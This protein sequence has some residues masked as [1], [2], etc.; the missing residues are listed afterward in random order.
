MCTRVRACIC[1]CVCVCV[2]VCVQA[3]ASTCVC[4]R[5]YCMCMRACVRVYTLRILPI[6]LCVACAVNRSFA[7]SICRS[8]LI[9]L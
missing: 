1:T 2:C 7:T 4:V 9:E 3:C 8:S 5:A 6:V